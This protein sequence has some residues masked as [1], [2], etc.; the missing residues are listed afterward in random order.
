[1]T[2]AT[3]YTGAGEVWWAPYDNRVG[4]ADTPLPDFDPFQALLWPFLDKTKSVFQCPD[5]FDLTPGSPTYGKPFQ[6]SY[7]MNFVTGGPNGLRLNDLSEGN[8]SS[9][10]LIIWHH[11]RTPGCANSKIS[12]PRGP[13][14]PYLDANDLTHYPQKRHG[15]V[16]DVLYCDGAVRPLAQSDILDRMFYARQP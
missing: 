12:A 6:V 5:G 11:G 14:K 9:N 1:L 16:F 7:G 8:G 2:S 13:W 3:L 10:I 4:P 15:G